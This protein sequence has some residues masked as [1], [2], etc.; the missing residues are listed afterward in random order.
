MSDYDPGPCE[1]REPLGVVDVSI[2]SRSCL[3]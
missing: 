3:D 2:H 1:Q